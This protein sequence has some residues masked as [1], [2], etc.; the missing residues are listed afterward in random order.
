MLWKLSVVLISLCPINDCLGS[1]P[2][3]PWQ[4]LPLQHSWLNS[5]EMR[6]MSGNQE[7]FNKALSQALLSKKM[8]IEQLLQ[9]RHSC[10]GWM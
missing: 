5:A 4:L 10:K 8:L 6:V 7:H 2:P 3:I 9:P 1:N